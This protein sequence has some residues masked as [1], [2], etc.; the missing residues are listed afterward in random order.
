MRALEI[1]LLALLLTPL[2][3]AS[4]S[5]LF[6]HAGPSLPMGDVA[7]RWDTGFTVGGGIAFPLGGSRRFRVEVGYDRFPADARGLFEE[8][9]GEEPGD[10]EV[11][12]GAAFS[13]FTALVGLELRM[14]ERA[15]VTTP[16]L[17]AGLGYALLTYGGGELLVDGQRIAVERNRD[18]GLGGSV[19]VGIEV[20]ATT[21]LFA[22]AEGRLAAAWAFDDPELYFPF[23]LGLSILP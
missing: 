14:G 17:A 2:A 12:E 16:Y 1:A 4:Q 20:A 9:S 21:N 22:F 23:R 15:G 10:A 13:T 8:S 7:R 11:V 5:V 19:G 6:F 3:G 18:S